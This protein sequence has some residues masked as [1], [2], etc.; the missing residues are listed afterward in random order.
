MKVTRYPNGNIHIR[1]HVRISNKISAVLLRSF[2]D[3]PRTSN[4]NPITGGYYIE[5][6]ISPFLVIRVEEVIPD[7]DE[8]ISTAI[9]DFII[10]ST[11]KDGDKD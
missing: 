11:I 2:N 8:F 6:R 4:I 10:P 1:T 3:I 7:G 5:C 9:Y